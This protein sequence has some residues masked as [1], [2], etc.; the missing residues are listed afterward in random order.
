M[1]S[2]SFENLDESTFD[3]Q[4]RDLEKFHMRDYSPAVAALKQMFP[5]SWKN[6]PLRSCPFVYSV[7]RELGSLYST[8]PSRTFE[9]VRNPETE[10]AIRKL[11]AS[12]RIDEIMRS[13]QEYLV[14]QGSCGIL[15]LPDPSGTPGLFSLHVLAPW[16]IKPDR[17][18][19]LI[20]D[21]RAIRRW[22]IRLPR[23]ETAYG[24]IQEDDLVLTPEAI[25]W[26][27]G[28]PYFETAENPIGPNI[29][30]VILR[31]AP[32]GTASGGRF[33]PVPNGDLL[34]AQL[35]LVCGYS[36]LG[37]ICSSQAWG[38]RILTGGNMEASEVQVG[39]DTVLALE[40]GHDFKIVSGD[41]GYQGFIASLESYLKLVCS[42]NKIDA[43]A[44][45][46]SGAYT[47][48]SRIVE[49]ADRTLERRIH[50]MECERAEGRIFRFLARWTNAIRGLPVFPVADISVKV[51]YH[52]FILPFDPLHE[53]QASQIRA[54]SGLESIVEQIAK[55]RG[56]SQDAA[57]L[58]LEENLAV[59]RKIKN[60]TSDQPPPE[61]IPKTIAV[62]FDGVLKPGA[63]D[64]T[65]GPTPATVAAL[66]Q[67]TLDGYRLI[68]VSSRPV[69][70]IKQ[71]L[72]DHEISHYFEEVT[73]TKNPALFYIDDRAIRFPGGAGGG[74]GGVDMIKQ[75][76]A[77]A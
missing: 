55:E 7:A 11:Y 34:A 66:E 58:V 30:L 24:T 64:S 39:P 50:I 46:S 47:A 21:E 49:R 56:I 22:R 60:A 4:S 28:T 1:L 42:Q 33:L 13:A 51:E 3:K 27:D 57:A 44:L 43:S 70:Q 29:P 69:D 9:G 32:A 5:T 17:P 26:A 63:F 45:L 61:F 16:R 62:D 48:A 40:E 74:D 76:R 25:T 72:A 54:S 14:I 18:S 23:K 75:G 12:T 71:W 36:D 38:Q 67:L 31:A 65:S 73:N 77:S 19:P 6:I 20:T 53:S 15:I 52:E 2:V 68:I 37:A 8:P 10:T 35:A 59:Q 41:S